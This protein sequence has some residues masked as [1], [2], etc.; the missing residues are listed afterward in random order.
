MTQIEVVPRHDYVVPVEQPQSMA[1]DNTAEVLAEN[2]PAPP[3]SN[4]PESGSVH[5]DPNAGDG[6]RIG[7]QEDRHSFPEFDFVETVETVSTAHFKIQTN[8][9]ETSDFKA[10]WTALTGSHEGSDDAGDV[11]LGDIMD[12]YGSAIVGELKNED[13][14][15]GTN[16]IAVSRPAP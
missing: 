9:L 3:K 12:S 11:S 8:L 15:Y 16:Q 6:Q 7:R 14:V 10:V 13:V 4:P 5:A 2:R 1:L